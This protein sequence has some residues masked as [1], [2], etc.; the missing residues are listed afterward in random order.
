MSS[1]NCRLG[2]LVLVVD[3]FSTP[4]RC[5]RSTSRSRASASSKP[6]TEKRPSQGHRADAAGHPD[7]SVDAGRRRVGGDPAAQGRPAHQGH[8]GDCPDRARADGLFRKRQA[9]RLRRLR[10][11][12]VPAG[13]AGRRGPAPARRAE[14][15][16]AIVERD[17]HMRKLSSI[18][19]RPASLPRRE[20]PRSAPNRPAASA[21]QTAD[22]A[23]AA[24]CATIRGAPERRARSGSPARGG[25]DGQPAARASM[26][27][28][29]SGP[30]SPCNSG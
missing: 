13:R 17:Q 22:A 25:R 6:R 15:R 2:P 8:S 11:E 26:S 29:S 18:A 1:D 12:A 21:A 10:D 30:A 27:T 24:T 9:G 19:R 28:A 7:G 4:V 20:H 23:S 16:R 14:D 5:T 3:D